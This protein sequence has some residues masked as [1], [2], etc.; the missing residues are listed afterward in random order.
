MSNL[1]IKFQSCRERE[2]VMV[3]GQ[4]QVVALSPRTPFLSGCTEEEDGTFLCQNERRF[5]SARE[6]WWF[7]AISNCNASKVRIFHYF[8][9]SMQPLYW[10]SA[11]LFFYLYT[12]T[13]VLIMCMRIGSL[14]PRTDSVAS[15]LRR[16]LPH[17]ARYNR[18]IVQMISSW[19]TN[20]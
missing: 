5:R 13:I 9:T 18:D 20:G 19:R 10:S 2:A 1:R 6:R 15:L 12:T 7:L 14:F 4:N 16:N 3:H 11:Y 17:W 8:Y